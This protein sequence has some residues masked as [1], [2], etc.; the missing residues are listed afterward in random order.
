MVITLQTDLFPYQESTLHFQFS[1][2]IKHPAC[3]FQAAQ[4]SSLQSD[5][6]YLCRKK[7]S[8]D[9]LLSKHHKPFIHASL[10]LSVDDRYISH[11]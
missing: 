11:I 3:I 5:L 6:V 4:G 10:I 7:S 9:F 1:M 8:G 2:I